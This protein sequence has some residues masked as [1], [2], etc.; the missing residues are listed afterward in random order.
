MAYTVGHQ[1]I[2]N[3]LVMTLMASARFSLRLE[4]ELKDWL[5]QEAKRKDRS[6]G[7]IATQ[8]IQTLKD[9]SDAKRRIIEEAISEADKG[10]FIS[11][12][13][14]TKWV[15][16][17]DTDNELPMPEPDIFLNPKR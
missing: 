10:V 12:E 11:E 4:P 7:Y 13:A 14:M 6:A 9:A 1:L 5:E 2:S 8:A 3:N 15:L 17:W 16:S